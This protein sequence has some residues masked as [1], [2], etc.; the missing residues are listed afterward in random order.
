MGVKSTSLFSME[1]P[2]KLASAIVSLRRFLFLEAFCSFYAC[3]PELKSS[4]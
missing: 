3:M 2:T 4:E 1:S